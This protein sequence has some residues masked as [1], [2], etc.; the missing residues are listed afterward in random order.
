MVSTWKGGVR[1]GEGE[2]GTRRASGVSDR[3]CVQSGVGGGG[4]GDT[5]PKGG[6]GRDKGE[7]ER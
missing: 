4:E 7:I 6:C 3:E 5:K 1:K 2:A